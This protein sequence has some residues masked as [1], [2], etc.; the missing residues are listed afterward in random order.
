MPSFEQRWLSKNQCKTNT[1]LIKI[2]ALSPISIYQLCNT[3][4]LPVNWA[5]VASKWPSN[6]STHFR[7][8]VTHLLRVNCVYSQNLFIR[9]VL[10][11]VI[12]WIKYSITDETWV[13]TEKTVDASIKTKLNALERFKGKLLKKKVCSTSV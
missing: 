12:T 4:M 5:S 6:V 9:I 10:I 11:S 2:S 13:E 1:F 3:L 7:C 8:W